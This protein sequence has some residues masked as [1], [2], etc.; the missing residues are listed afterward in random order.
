MAASLLLAA[1]PAIA[2]STAG[3]FQTIFSGRKK[4]Q[5]ELENSLNSNPIYNPNKGVLDFYQEALN[6]ANQSTY[7]TAQFQ[8]AQKNAQRTT[9]TGISGLQDR[10]SALAGISRLTGIE[11][12][13]M[14]NAIVQ[15]E[16]LNN[17]RFRELGT[18]T[19]MKASEEGKA[20]EI[21]RLTPYQRRL[22]MNMMK[23]S[24]ANERFNA[25]LSNLF[26]GG[27]NAASIFG[28]GVGKN[29][30]GDGVTPNTVGGNRVAESTII[31]PLSSY[32][33]VVDRPLPTRNAFSEDEF[34]L[35]NFIP[36]KKI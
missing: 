31:N 16:Q 17:Q 29:N 1:A 24:A 21:N 22:Q 8:N 34:N 28:S 15:A 27:A 11:N 13:A 20:F 25:G 32:G 12:D 36:R 4:A 18:A 2:Q 10:R 3:L 14:N 6:R 26:S 33:Q 30:V 35:D 7:Q 5:R 23:S 9:A 19:G